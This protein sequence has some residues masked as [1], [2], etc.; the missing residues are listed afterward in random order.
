MHV[1][2]VMRHSASHGDTRPPHG[3][4][5]A[6]PAVIRGRSRRRLST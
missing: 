1:R 4:P 6:S 2:D 5:P 3:S